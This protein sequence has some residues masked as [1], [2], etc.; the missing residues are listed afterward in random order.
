MLPTWSRP[1]TSLAGCYQ[2]LSQKDYSAITIGPLLSSAE[3]AEKH[4]ERVRA[5]LLRKVVA[6]A[7]R[8]W[9]WY[10]ESRNMKFKGWQH[11]L[12]FR[13]RFVR[14]WLLVHTPK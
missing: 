9:V 8:A 3:V 13:N 5:E 1:I 12:E 6:D 14:S 10:V 4:L 11:Y 7:D 2:S